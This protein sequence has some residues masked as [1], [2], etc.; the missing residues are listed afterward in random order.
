MQKRREE[1]ES[2]RELQRKLRELAKSPP[3]MVLSR[4]AQILGGFVDLKAQIASLEQLQVLTATSL[5][6][7]RPTTPRSMLRLMSRAP[8]RAFHNILDDVFLQEQRALCAS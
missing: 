4:I 5:S 8:P 3:P 6:S 1:V 2:Q 7:G